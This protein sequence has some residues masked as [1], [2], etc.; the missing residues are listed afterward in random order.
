MWTIIGYWES[1]VLQLF[2]QIYNFTYDMLTANLT[3]N[4]N[5]SIIN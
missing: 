1:L 3:F 5:L 2:Q 4:N